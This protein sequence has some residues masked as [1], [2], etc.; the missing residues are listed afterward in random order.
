M[1]FK[2]YN[3][4]PDKMYIIEY[5]RNNYYIGKYLDT[6]DEYLILNNVYTNMFF[7]GHKVCW[8]DKFTYYRDKIEIDKKNILDIKPVEKLSNYLHDDALLEVLI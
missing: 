2:D 6:T 5:L 4:E 8:G 3:F 7:D 1:S